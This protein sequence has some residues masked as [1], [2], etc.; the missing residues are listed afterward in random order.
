MKFYRYVDVDIYGIGIVIE[1]R[2]Y[3]L[4]R[5]TEKGYW[6]KR[7]GKERWVSKNSKKRFAYPSKEQALENYVARKK[8]QIIILET[9]LNRAKTALYQAEKKII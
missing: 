1:I 6:I 7:H 4:I 5:T 2:D 3:N 8:R 9:Q